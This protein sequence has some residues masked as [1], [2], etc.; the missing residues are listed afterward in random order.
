M[1]CKKCGNNKVDGRKKEMYCKSC[2]EEIAAENKSKWIKE[3][4]IRNE[5]DEILGKL[6][7]PQLV[8]DVTERIRGA[9]FHQIITRLIAYEMISIHTTKYAR[10]GEIEFSMIDA[11]VK[12]S[13][14]EGTNRD[15]P[16][17]TYVMESMI[18]QITDDTKEEMREKGIE[19][20]YALGYVL[21]S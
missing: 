2:L 14:M 1:K 4:A 17:I 8:R 9:G 16:Y 11:F 10:E 7:T 3:K 12:A 5:I 13:E 15:T 20:P 19:E 6:I 21:G 18:R